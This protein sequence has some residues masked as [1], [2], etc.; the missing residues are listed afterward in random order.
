M[1]SA[2][3]VSNN[4]S[5]KK[6]IGLVGIL[7]LST[8][9]GILLV[10]NASANV[11]G[12]YE[13]TSTIYPSQNLTM[14]S[15]DTFSFTVQVS[16][17]GFFYNSQAR[18]IEWFTCEGIQDESTC[19]NDRDDYGIGSI[20][21]LQVGESL[22]YTFPNTF[23]P[24]G[25]EG[26]Y[27]VV[28]R[29][30]DSDTNPSN[31]V[32]IYS[33]DLVQNLVDVIFEEQNPIE[34]LTGLAEYDGE[35]V[36]N[37]GVNYTMD[38]SG[39]VNSCL[40][41][42]LDA[43]LGWKLVDQQGI[44]RANATISY[45]NLPD[46]GTVAFTR[47]MP[48]LNFDTEGVYEMY[49]GIF[50]STG[51]PSG[52]MNSF[53]DLQ[54]I[55]VTFDDTI[56]L[57]VTSMYPRNV[58]NSADYFYG[59]NSV[60]VTVSNLG[61]LSAIEP[62]VRFTVMNLNDQIDSQED[63]FPDEIKPAQTVECAFDLNHL[64]DKKLSV[65]VGAFEGLDAKPADNNLDVQAEIVIGE[66]GPLIEQSEFFGQYNTADNITFT[67]RTASTAA[68]PLNYTWWQEGVRYLGHGKVLTIPADMVGLGD[69]L[70]SVRAT[71]T[72]GY[73]ETA[74]TLVT[75]YNST[76]ISTGDWLTGSAV[77]RTHAEAIATYDYPLAGVNYGPG[78]DLEA[79]IRMSIDVVPTT[80]ELDAGMDWME[81]DINISNMIP[82]NV[83]RDSISVRQLVDYDQAYWSP[84]IEENYFQ[85]IDNDTVRVHVTENMD[86][87][88]VGELPPP[89][90]EL[91][92]PNITLLPDGK[93]RLD[94]DATGDIENP[95]FGGWKI[96]RVTS[97]ITASTYFPDPSVTTSEFIWNGLMQ[98]GLSATLDGTVNT[99]TD[100]RE[101][102]TGICSSYA[103]MP[104][105]RMGNP[106]FLNA[107]V[108]LS[109]GQPGLTCGDAI[110][111]L[112]EVSGFSSS[113]IFNNDTICYE[114]YLDWNKCYELTLTWQW[115]NNEPEG[116]IYWN[117]YRI[118]QR[119]SDID[120]RYIE[121]IATGIQ[122]IPGEQG[123]FRQN[124]TDYE[125]IVPYRTYYYILTPMDAVG[126][127]FTIVEYP[128]QNV[129]R[130][131]IEDKYWQFNEHRI[132][133]EPEPEEPPYGV[134]WLGDLE[135]YMGVENFQV[136]GMIMLLT[137]LINFIGLP[138]I[139]KKRKR[140]KRVLAKRAGNKP[141][142]LDDDFQDFFN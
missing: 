13:I 22:N 123:T 45:T 49:F 27:T 139:L 57:Q 61:N 50:N 37:T 63:C 53:N 1:S 95:Y 119:P 6:S 3:A 73:T 31:D 140:M 92:N 26:T 109:N 103:L 117:I 52:D 35:V 122:N 51:T 75:V 7:L 20:E 12:D 107:K 72:L 48:P 137:I 68:A 62:L 4:I 58:P 81:F 114:T 69:H 99:W 41:C 106:D 17:S 65:F 110:D 24:D 43:S 80:E 18:T 97:P 15:W 108:T 77:T 82:E 39:I 44:E 94:W 28:Y 67:A 136:A 126:N 111:P 124:G 9:S 64:G 127:E 116:E 23:S 78:P 86:L 84:L 29:F 87:L 88:L 21:S 10:P 138:L 120:L 112:S 36:L 2:D 131:Y 102:Q 135:E 132:P 101:L 142:D 19:F 129:E 33:F 16:N 133:E 134:E 47:V 70:I 56:D 130:V 60:A 5:S 128:S 83:P 105:D 91:S 100:E 54:S 30:V 14:S 74:I 141:A 59:D 90:I 42:N 113:V 34:Q 121:P 89:E 8:L 38:I 11:S 40:T 66:I 71:D 46:W 104:T 55:E 118:E 96:Y 76:D 125:G 98:G 93:M 115:P 32:A 85:L 25:A 79:L